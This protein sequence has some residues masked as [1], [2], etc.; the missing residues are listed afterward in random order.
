MASS[1]V[2]FVS[3]TASLRNEMYVKSA[4]LLG[5]SKP[6]ILFR[7]ILPNCTG[8][9]LTKATLDMG[10]VILTG[11][12][13]SFVGLGEQPPLPALGTMVS[14][15]AKYLPAQWRLSIFPALAIMIAVL[16]FN[17]MVNGVNFTVYAGEKVAI[18]G[19]TGCGKTTTVKSILRIF[20]K[21]SRVPRGEI[22]FRGRNVLGMKDDE[23]KKLRGAGV[24]MIFQDPTMFL[25]P[26]FTIGEQMFEAIRNSGREGC[27]KRDTQ[28][29]LA[30]LALKQTSM[31]DPERILISY[32]FQLSGGMRQRVCIAMSLATP[33]EMVIADEPPLRSA[34]SSGRK[35]VP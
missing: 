30:V 2:N 14:G 17:L 11:A 4:E 24:S 1:F 15:G 25:N 28:Q 6:H 13:L 21:N 18:V 9:I 16:G 19:E 3:M 7:E 20:A 31:P 12:T 26:V 29:E 32:P 10:W 33:R 8:S 35:A 34:L 5:A 23:L 22:L 27:G